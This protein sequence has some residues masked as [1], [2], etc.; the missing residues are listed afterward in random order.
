MKFEKA[1]CP[2]CG[3]ALKVEPDQRSTK[4]EYCN[5]VVLISG[6]RQED[7]SGFS[8]QSDSNAGKENTKPGNIGNNGRELPG[9]AAYS[10]LYG[11]QRK[12][13]VR[14]QN[15]TERNMETAKRWRGAASLFP[16]PGFRTKDVPHM[17]LAVIGYLFILA[18]AGSLGGFKD[19][20]F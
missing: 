3:A 19:A 4:C 6:H 17:I 9:E 5:S 18:V 10:D 12:N 16:P 8:N 15:R 2:Y 11:A 14:G 7:A 20:L 1:V 13:T